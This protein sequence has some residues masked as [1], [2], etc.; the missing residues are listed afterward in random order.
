MSKKTQ[1]R[2]VV[3]CR[4]STDDNQSPVD[5]KR[6]QVEAATSA[7]GTNATI[8]G[9]R[10]DVDVSRSV[11]WSRRREASRLLDEL[12]LPHRPWDGIAIGE[13]QRAFGGSEQYQDVAARLG[14][15]GAE[16]W[17]PEVGGRVDFDSEAHE[18]VLSLFGTLSK[19]ER[20]RLRRRVKAGMTAMARTGERFLGGRP[21]YG[22]M[23]V[24]T[25]EP[26]PNPE[27]ARYGVTLQRLVPNPETA[28]VVERIFKLRTDGAGYRAIA[29]ALDD[30]GIPCP[31]AADPARNSHRSGK[32]WQ[33]STVRAILMNPRYKG[34]DRWG[35]VTKQDVLA[36]ASDPGKGTRPARVV[37]PDEEVIEVDGALPPLVAPE[38]W[39][40]LERER[41]RRSASWASRENRADTRE[42][43]R[44][45]PTLADG[46]RPPLTGLVH[47]GHCGRRMTVDRQRTKYDSTV[48][49]WQC[50]A[51]SIAPELRDDHPSKVNISNLKASSLIDVWIASILDPKVFD[52]DSV[53]LAANSDDHL[54]ARRREL[55]AAHATARQKLDRALALMEDPDYPLDR[56]KARVTALRAE[57]ERLEVELAALTRSTPRDW[58]GDDVRKVLSEVDGLLGAL[59][60]VPTEE[61]STFRS[62][63][64]EVLGLR[65]TFTSTGRGSGILRADLIPNRAGSGVNVWCRRGDLNPHAL[66]GTSTSS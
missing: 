56:A 27:K 46:D 65:A 26:H 49:R 52:P 55:D 61:A 43:L 41:A 18:L 16:L 25:G 20:R 19:G 7:V 51:R 4:T 6:W 23:L 50:R 62:S 54:R 30:D 40:E 22:F 39:D 58:T 38:V 15:W 9:V 13:P 17:V 28:P 45:P 24:S 64:Y 5:S 66:A 29:S 2:L 3:Y 35:A 44:R 34:V 59:K 37:A 53:A 32:G 57:V 42:V 31:S 63:V 60:A 36:D 11:P 33:D 48:I 1:T 12:V 47:C 14:H 8:I 10:H 21:P